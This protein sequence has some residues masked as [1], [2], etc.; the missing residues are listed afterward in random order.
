MNELLDEARKNP[1]RETMRR[2]IQFRDAE[3]GN[4]CVNGEIPHPGD[5]PVEH[6]IRTIIWQLRDRRALWWARESEKPSFENRKPD[7]QF[8]DVLRWE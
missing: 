5:P 3:R 8:P 6:T 1:T 2:M 7:V 4:V